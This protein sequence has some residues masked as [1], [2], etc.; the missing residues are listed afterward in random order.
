MQTL[1]NIP[2]HK[3][4]AIAREW[5]RR[6]QAAQAEAR[7]AREPDFRTARLHALHDKRG[8]LIRE[9][10]SYREGREISWRIIRSIL[11]RVNQVDLILNGQHYHTGS[12]EQ[13]ELAV[14]RGY[15]V[16]RSKNNLKSNS[17]KA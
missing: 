1:Q 10:M 17:N 2:R 14:A 8:E 4:R 6:S 9:G 7:K 5:G 15:W 11:G 12:L 3:R 13:A 16:I